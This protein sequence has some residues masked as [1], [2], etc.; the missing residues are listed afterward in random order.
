MST[1]ETLAHSP[2][3]VVGKDEC[4]RVTIAALTEVRPSDEPMDFLL[5]EL[6]RARIVPDAMVPPDVV[7]LGSVVRYRSMLGE[8]RTIKL[9]MPDE[10]EGPSGYRLPVTSLHGAALLGLRAGATMGWLEA[11]GTKHR[12]E[13]LSVIN[14]EPMDA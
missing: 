10:I 9:V 4:R 14:P 8:E 11:D 13:V 1:A 3:T 5:Y 12:I 6:K 7:R 2:E